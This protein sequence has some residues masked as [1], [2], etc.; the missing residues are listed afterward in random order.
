MYKAVF[1]MLMGALLMA[2]YMSGSADPFINDTLE[3]LK[4]HNPL[5]E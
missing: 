4:K 1:Y 5:V 3:V 2:V